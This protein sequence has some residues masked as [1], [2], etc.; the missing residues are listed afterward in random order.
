MT[1]PAAPPPPPSDRRDA[2][3]AAVRAY[4]RVMRIAG[5]DWRGRSE[6]IDAYPEVRPEDGPDEAERQVT[7]AICYAAA[8]HGAWFWR[9]VR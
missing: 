4:R 6:A 9:G 3:R 7:R 2:W 8:H 5:D 1:D